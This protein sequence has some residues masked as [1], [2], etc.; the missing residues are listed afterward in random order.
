MSDVDEAKILTFA[1]QWDVAITTLSN[2]RGDFKLF[3]ADNKL[4]LCWKDSRQALRLVLDFLNPQIQKR[5]KQGLKKEPLIKALGKGI[6]GDTL[7]I[8]AT[9]GLGRDGLLLAS[10]GAKLIWLEQHPLIYLLLRDA[11]NR[12]L[13]TQPLNIALFNC[14]ALDYLKHIQIRP[15]IIYLDPMFPPRTKTALV[16]KEMQIL[17][18]LHED[19][20]T[21]EERLLDLACQVSQKRVIVKRPAYAPSLSP[22]QVAFEI[23]SPYH[24]FDVY[25]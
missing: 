23:K 2:Q 7:I 12:L 20:P 13:A 10:T 15:D 21:E 8:D 18:A 9:A 4:G 1:R 17:Q 14:S 16:K 24:R 25:S 3:Y 11:L 22:H 5:L 19:V 6:N